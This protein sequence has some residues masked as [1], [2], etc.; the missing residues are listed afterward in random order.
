MKRLFIFSFDQVR[1][2]E[3]GNKN[4]DL[5]HVEEAYTTEHWIVRIY[6]V[7]KLSNRLQAKDALRRVRRLKSIY[8]SAKKSAEQGQK[9][10]VILNKPQIKKG[11]K[12]SASKRSI[13]NRQRL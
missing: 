10:G 8:S 3:I 2:V 12:V 9:Q 4:F 13:E 11:T 5:Q 1:H 7:K 6:K